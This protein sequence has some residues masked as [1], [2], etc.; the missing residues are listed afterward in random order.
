MAAGAVSSGDYGGVYTVLECSP[1]GGMV[2]CVTSTDIFENGM[3]RTLDPSTLTHYW[4]YIVDG[5]QYYSPPSFSDSFWIDCGYTRSGYVRV[6]A[7]G[8]V[9]TVFFACPRQ[10]AYEW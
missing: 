2:F 5:Q 8:S 10:T 4:D 3:W 1:Y 7:G 6:S 9:A